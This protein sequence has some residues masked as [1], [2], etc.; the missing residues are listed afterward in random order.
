MPNATHA[1]AACRF[2]TDPGDAMS[3]ADARVH[4]ALDSFRI[5][6]PSWGFANTG[7]RFGKFLQP[8]AAATHR[9]EIQRRGTGARADRGLPDARPARAV[10]SSRGLGQR[11]GSRAPVA[12]AWRPRRARSIRTCSRIS[13]YKYGS[14]GNPDPAVRDAAL[15]HVADSV[16]IAQALSSRDVSLWFAD[17][18]NYPGTAQHPP[19]PRVVRRGPAAPPRAPRRRTSGCWSSTSRSSRRSI[20]PT[21]P[22]GGWRCCSRARPVRRRACSS[23]PAITTR[24]RTSSRSSPGCSPRACSA[25][26]ISTID[27]MPTTT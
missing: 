1:G 9:G 12:P 25:A 19:A 4:A 23:T 10:G 3:S 24:R 5:E 21:S 20:T 17:G 8:A 18:S 6:V 7:T 14:F 26:F 13:S 16:A 2:R 22:T 15:R 27:A 11:R